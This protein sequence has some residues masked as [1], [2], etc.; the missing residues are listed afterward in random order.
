MNMKILTPIKIARQAIKAH[1][2]RAMLTVL[3]LVIGVSSMILVTNL[4]GGVKTIILGQVE[5]FGTDF[6]QI[7]VK[8]PT[9]AKNSF[10]GAI[11]MA[12]GVSVTTLKIGDAEAI[13]KHPNIKD[14]FAGQISQQII[15]Y[16]GQHKTSM[17][18]GVSP[19]FFNLFK[20]NIEEGRSFFEEEDSSRSLVAVLGYG[21]KEKFFYNR[22][23]VGNII[24]IGNKNFRVIGTMEERGADIF[25][26][27][28][29][30]VFMPVQTLQKQL[31]GIDHLVFIT[32]YLNDPSRADETAE[33]ITE[34][35]RD[36]HGITDPKN[37]DFAVTTTE[38]MMQMLNTIT[39]AITLLLAAIAAISL[40]VG[41]VGIMNVMYVSVTERTYE[42]G[43]RKAV[44]ATK[45][46]I[47]WQFMWEA[48]FLTL[49]GG[50]VGIIIGEFLSVIIVMAVNY[51]GIPWELS[52]SYSGLILGVVFSVTVGLVFGIYP[53]KHAASLDPVEALIAQ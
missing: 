23:A 53:A 20:A 21:L 27:L 10:E 51:F 25:Y 4:G 11:S 43:L 52:I 5:S 29:N 26:D 37:D 28:D 34:I 39:G 49:V 15:R 40:V 1:K 36:R 13:V 31:L 45:K 7:E 18:W 30:T 32:A 8:V 6:L 41:G 24:K 50:F 33:D 16:D 12:Q 48:I 2:T 9:T 47:L 44:G 17:I 46:A 38:E 19:S 3:G 35:L 14:Y 42:I 22:E